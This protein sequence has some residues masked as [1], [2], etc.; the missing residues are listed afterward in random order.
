[1]WLFFGTAPAKR[2]L[3][4]PVISPSLHGCV[5]ALPADGPSLQPR[6]AATPAARL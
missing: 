4:R 1:M 6:T 5:L 3:E 2:F